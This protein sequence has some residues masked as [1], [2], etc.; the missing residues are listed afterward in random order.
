MTDTRE[1]RLNSIDLLRGIA[2]VVMALDHV[3][4]FF[5]N[6]HFDPLDLTQT[7][8]LLFITR[9]VTHHCAPAFVFLAGT[10]AFLSLSRGKTSK[11]LSA[12]LFTRGLWLVFLELTV[13]R[14]AWSFNFDYSRIVV[15]VIWAIGWS[16]VFLAMLVRLPRQI[17][18]IISFGMIA[19]HNLFDGIAPS[20]LGIFGWAWQVLHVRGLI[21]YDQGNEFFVLYPLI[22]WLGVIGAGYLFGGVLK[23]EERARR[24]ALYRLGFGLIG[25]FIVLRALNIYGDPHPWAVQDTIIKTVL[26][27]INTTKYPPS[28]L[29]LMMTL[30]PAIAALPLLERWHGRFADFLTVYGRVPM[31]YYV[32]HI[33]LI[34]SLALVAG[35]L[36]VGDIGF[37]FSKHGFGRYPATYGFDLGEV[38][39]VWVFVVLVLYIPC[40]WFMGVKRRNRSVWLSYL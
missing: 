34:H 6:T 24:V 2:M 28:L 32:V 14:V 7:T 35:M 39:L 36:T 11:D 23:L 8:P 1:P 13:L 31:F 37:M 19:F 25:G 38:Y 17:I 40:R 29:Y 5:S 3:R 12:F 20:S 26:S 16:M 21:I 15:Q 33:F 10:G 9:W 22:P 30:G 4:D 18:A 27:F